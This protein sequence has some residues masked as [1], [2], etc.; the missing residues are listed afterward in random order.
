V[1][2]HDFS[3]ARS[4]GFVLAL[5]IAVGLQRIRPHARFSGSWQTN[6][7]LWAINLVVLGTVCGAC[8][9]TAARW[10]ETKGIGLFSVS[11]APR[12][13][14]VAVSVLALDLVSYCWHR[15]NHQIPF[16][17]R[18]HRVHHSDIAFTV[19]TGTRFHPGELVLSLPLRVAA[20]VLLGAP[21]EG[22]LLFELVFNIA[23]LVEHGDT[24]VPVA[25]EGA[26]G[27]VL[28]TPALHR[29][30][31]S[32]HWANLNTNFG[33]IFAVWD[34]LFGTYRANSSSTKVQT[35]LPG[36]TGPIGFRDALLLPALRQA[37]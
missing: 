22:V 30:H 20:V 3:V 36:V 35:G 26:L 27:R 16:L 24:N 18:F 6:G 37:R 21:P 12:W 33:T 19:S 2:E 34:H 9:C 13:V 1:T 15:A 10:A 25:V 31:H 32:R 14:A 17:W 7:G 4:V 11:P 28:I 23:N 8:V 5:V 29:F